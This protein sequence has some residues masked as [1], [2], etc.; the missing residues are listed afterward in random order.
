[1]KCSEQEQD[2]PIV[3]EDL[4]LRGK[5]PRADLQLPHDDLNR[6]REEKKGDAGAPHD[7]AHA[8]TRVHRLSTLRMIAFAQGC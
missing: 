7:R 2:V 6:E 8:T 1:M 5:R 4:A 3:R